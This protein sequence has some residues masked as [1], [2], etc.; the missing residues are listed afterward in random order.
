MSIPDSPEVLADEGFFGPKIHLFQSF[1]SD[2]GGVDDGGAEDG[3]GD[4]NRVGNVGEDPGD[5][6]LRIKGSIRQ[7]ILNLDER[8]D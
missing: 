8:E 5:S 6:T 3:S 1:D 7:S 2:D 4:L